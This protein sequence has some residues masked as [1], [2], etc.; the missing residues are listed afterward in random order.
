MSCTGFAISEMDIFNVL[1]AN[2]PQV[3]NPENKILL[4]LAEAEFEDWDDDLHERVETSA[5][6]ADLTGN[7]EDDLGAQ[8]NEAYVEIYTILVERG[9]LRSK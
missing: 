6:A 2:R 7:D 3:V 4:A 9:V 5:L 1:E 8:T